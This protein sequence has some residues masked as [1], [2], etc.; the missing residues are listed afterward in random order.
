MNEP[1]V[2]LPGMM[3]DGRLYEPQLSRFTAERPVMLVPLV[4]EST[5]AG[6]ASSILKIA[7]PTFALGGLSMGGIV[8]MEMVRQAPQRVTRLGLFDTNPLPDP[9][10]KAPIRQA[11]C[12][13]VAAGEL[14]TVMKDEMKPNYLADGP[15]L[16]SVLDLCM[17]MAES[18]G[19]SVFLDQSIALQN[20]PDQCDTLRGVDAPA[21][22]LCGESDQ[23]CPVERHE[24]MHELLPDSRLVVV[25]GAGH[26][27][28]LEQPDATNKA[29]EEWLKM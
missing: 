19:T 20:R 4:G 5:I 12:A 27:P 6:L 29:I 23:L 28:T 21:L 13:K 2:L 7:P 16:E 22:V 1:L 25:R 8:A 3:C 11:Q 9:P 17:E 10:E 24:L 26:L 14:R 18:L 15:A